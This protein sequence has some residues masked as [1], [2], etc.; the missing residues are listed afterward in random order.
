M[1]MSDNQEATAVNESRDGVGSG[2]NDQPYTFGLRPS[3]A[4]L[5]PFTFREYV[6][7]QMLRGRFEDP[8]WPMV[9]DVS[10]LA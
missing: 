6:R 1:I 7:L 10:S 8:S 9:L 2:D 4:A 5:S 3:S